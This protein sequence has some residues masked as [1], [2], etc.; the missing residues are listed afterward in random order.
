MNNKK[1]L[2]IVSLLILI[3]SIFGISFALLNYKKTGS[4]SKLIVGDIYMHYNENDETI[5]TTVEDT[6]DF[7]Y[8]GYLLNSDM[9]NQE[10][11]TL[12]DNELSKCVDY[13][14][15]AGMP[16]ADGDTYITYCQGTG[17]TNLGKTFQENLTEGDW[18]SDTILNE[19]KN[20]NIVTSDNKINSIMASQ[21]YEDTRNEL[22]KCADYFY[23]KY[24]ANGFSNA[25]TR[26]YK[27]SKD[28]VVKKLS[29][30]SYTKDDYVEFCKG[31]SSID[32][33][34][35]NQYIYN[36]SDE[37]YFNDLLSMNIINEYNGIISS[38]ETGNYVVNEDLLNQTYTSDTRNELSKCVDILVDY[39]YSESDAT[40]LCK[41]E[42]DGNSTLEEYITNG[43]FSSS[44]ITSLQENNIISST[45]TINTSM[46]SQSYTTDTRSE[47]SK[48]VDYFY[49]F[50]AYD[51]YAKSGRYM[52]NVKK[53]I[54]S[55]NINILTNF[56][57][58]TGTNDGTDS[59]FNIYTLLSSNS[60]SGGTVS[61][62]TPISNSTYTGESYIKILSNKNIIVPEL[63]TLPYFEFTI[64]G[65]N[66]SSKDIIYN[67]KLVHG[68]VITNKTE[69]NRISDKFII[70]KLVKVVNNKEE[71]LVNNKTFDTINNTILYTD[72]IE[73]NTSSTINYTYRL[74]MLIDPN[75]TV[76]N[77]DKSDYSFDEYSNLFASIKVDVDG[78]YE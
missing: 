32:N 1:V 77:T 44:V 26:N 75:L 17:K 18:F 66:T 45:N 24:G 42:S 19:L 50:P 30:G 6:S 48:C 73:K 41:G 14:N 25:S 9:K 33:T 36:L 11:Q 28:I 51:P 37:E 67:I 46:A 47:L 76:G 58:G 15:N 59:G 16:L 29:D 61:S 63:E 74:Y 38:Y 43:D 53:M 23:S 55:E 54:S 70:F 69:S 5:L 8:N 64:D 68:D 71:E 57:N 22:S 21:T 7:Y 62:Y 65:K 31:T 78:N 60:Y 56:C 72:K 39:G 2:I 12:S 20:L 10:Y 27:F 13:F 3:I 4:D 49:T 34:T 52:S 35:L 40:S